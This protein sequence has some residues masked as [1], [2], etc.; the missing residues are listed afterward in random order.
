MLENANMFYV[1]K[2][3]SARQGLGSPHVSLMDARGVFYAMRRE[4]N[5]P[6]DNNMTDATNGGNKNSFSEIFIA[7]NN[8]T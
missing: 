2:I 3:K 1:S 5:V 6:D 7:S 8:L 4:W